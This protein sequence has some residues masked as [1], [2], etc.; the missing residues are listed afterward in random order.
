MLEP[1]QPRS[2]LQWR[3]HGPEPDPVTAHTI[4]LAFDFDDTLA[5]DSTSQVLEAVGIEPQAFWRD[6][7]ELM[8]QGWDQVPA[9]MHMML[10]RSR[11]AGRPITRD[12]ITRVGQELPLYPGV[13]SMF[14]RYRRLIEADEGFRA[15][16]FVISGGL[17]DLVAATAIAGSFD[18]IWGSNFAYG[19][20][21]VAYAV[22]NAISFTD[23]TRFLF[24]I[25]KGLVG[26]AARSAPFAV[27]ERTTDFPV[28]F[29][30]IIY[31]GDGYT[32]IPCFALIQKA[33]GRAIAAYD[34]DNRTKVGR[35]YGFVDDRRVSHVVPTNY[36]KNRAADSAIT[37][38]IESI[39]T[40][41]LSEP[42]A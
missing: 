34:R 30:N 16:F 24:Q 7:V 26:P 5:P 13:K 31:L 25:S 40:R 17:A 41:I 29:K 37:L 9:W 3:R 27:N 32:D 42:T 8:A 35:V 10:E 20:D 6:H 4:A 11:A 21:G 38:A 15:Q 18:D 28:P 39:K 22:K 14:R 19:A 33:G 23:K 1:G 12:L 2:P 36:T